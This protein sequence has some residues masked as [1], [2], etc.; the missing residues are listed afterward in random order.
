MKRFIG[1]GVLLM[2]ASGS[3]LAQAGFGGVSGAV[4]DATQA[5][6]RSAAVTLTGPNGESRTTKTDDSG[7]Y[8]FAALPVGGGYTVT[9]SAKGFETAKVTGLSTTVGTVLTQNVVLKV[10]SESQ[11]VEVSAASVEQVQLD[12][13]SVSQLIDNTIFEAS[14]LEVRTQNSFVYLVAGAANSVDTGRGAAMDGAR[15]G[16][17]NFLLEGV[18]NNDQG[19]GG[20]GYTY[21]VGGALASISPDAIQEYRVITHN[22]PAEYGRTGGFTTDTVLKSGTNHFH[23]SLFEYNRIQALAAESWFSKHA[24][25]QLRNHLVRNQFGGSV[26]GPI[27]SDRTFFN[28]TVEIHH[29]RQSVP[30]VGT[31]TTQQFLT[32]VDSGAFET[33]QESNAAGLCMVAKGSACPGGFSDAHALGPVFKSLMA[34]EP[35]AFP[36]GTQNAT[37]AADGLYT[38]PVALGCFGVNYPVPVYATVTE[39]QGQSTDQNRGSMKIDHKLTEKDQLGFAYVLDFA[40][41]TEAFGGGGSTFGPDASINNGAQVFAANWTHTFSPTLQNLFRG[42][43]TRHVGNHNSPDAPGVPQL[44]TEDALQAGFGSNENYPQLFTEN[45]FLYEDILTKDVGRHSFKV[46]FRYLRTRNGSSFDQDINGALYPWD[47]ESLVTDET[48][49]DQADRAIPPSIGGGPYGSIAEAK[50]AVDSTTNAA[51][52]PYRGYR[53]NEYA[54]YVQDDW[55]ATDR[56]TFNIGLRWDYFGPPHNFQAGYDS[57]VFFGAFAAPTPNGNPFLPNST[58]IGAMQ[59]A[60]FQVVPNGGQSSLWNKDANNIGPRLGFAY[61]PTGSG[62]TAIRGGFGIGYD[63]MYNNIFENIRF[64]APRYSDNTIGYLI[65]SVTAGA[66]EQPA[67]VNVPFTANNL[68]AAYGGLPVPRHVDQRLVTAY[69]EQANLGVEHEIAKGYVAEVNYIGTF[70]RKLVGVEDANNYDG[71]TACSGVSGVQKTRCTAAGYP[72]GFTSARPNARFTTD[73]YRYNGFNSNYNGLQVSVRKA[74]SDGLMFLA[75]YTYSKAMDEISDFLYQK[76]GQN[77]TADP[78]NPGYDYGPADFDVKHSA[79]LTLNYVS[80]WH[81]KSLLL[82]GWGISP[83]ISMQSGTPFSIVDSASTY[84]PNKDGR[85]LDRAVYTGTGGYKNAIMH[86]PR[87]GSG[88]YLSAKQFAP[89]ACPATVNMGLWCDPPMSRNAFYGPGY[90]NAD[91]AVSKHFDVTESQHVIAQVAFFNA[92]NHPNFANPVSDINSP[93]FG[94]SQQINPGQSQGMRVTQLSLRYEF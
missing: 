33:F 54:A 6:I 66:L 38:C 60:T 17:G 92:F 75:N 14:P 47:I 69:Y 44:V 76:T 28:A 15:S 91:V 3:A 29:A 8:L 94:T 26:G 85:L 23:G 22:Q 11:T 61:D 31:T 64:N 62:K 68:F 81:K 77:G 39:S 52:N 49:D 48:F 57:N 24:L 82:G 63:R 67:L 45:E 65:G 71:R 53:A 4:T 51:P 46:G 80:Q 56:L 58:F 43:Y 20:G 41:T 90:W 25:P 78:T 30:K 10:G 21:L 87:P 40:S 79:V 18:D 93:T 50:A 73:N 12:D 2:V 84:D 19:Q 35:E 59:G 83:I 88:G 16:T 89:Y 74:Y 9:V 55:R 32:F 27:L 34:A 13:S 72:K 5:V 86:N 1:V 42:G 7:D 36:L 37:N 70:G